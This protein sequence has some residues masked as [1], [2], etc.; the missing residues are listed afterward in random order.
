MLLESQAKQL[1]VETSQTGGGAA[2]QG[3]FTAG[4][5]EQWAG[6]ALTIST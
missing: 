2:S 5:G 4:V 6:V 1:V 3:T